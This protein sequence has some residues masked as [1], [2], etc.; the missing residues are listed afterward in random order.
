MVLVR[1]VDGSVISAG[2]G[3]EY[4]SAI[5]TVSTIPGNLG[6]CWDPE[7]GENQVMYT[8]NWCCNPFVPLAVPGPV[9][10]GIVPPSSEERFST[11]SDGQ[12]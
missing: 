1:F 12:M 11:P 9:F 5:I 7:P 6:S 8:S 4:L 3:W 2:F 10:R